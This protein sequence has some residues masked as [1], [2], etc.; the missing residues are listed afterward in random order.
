MCDL[1]ICFNTKMGGLISTIREVRIIALF[2]SLMKLNYV[3]CTDC[4][5]SYA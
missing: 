3:Y 1:S 5:V 4:A 2:V